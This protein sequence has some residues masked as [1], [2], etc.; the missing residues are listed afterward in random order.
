[1]MIAKL[2]LALISTMIGRQI[3]GKLI[4]FSKL[5]FSRNMFWLRSVISENNPQASRPAHR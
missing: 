4:F 3:R 2:I 1:M 5:A